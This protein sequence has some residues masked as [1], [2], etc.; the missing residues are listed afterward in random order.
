[1]GST[2]LS[3]L[4]LPYHQM[5]LLDFIKQTAGRK[6]GRRRRRN[7]KVEVKFKKVFSQKDY[8]E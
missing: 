3:C 8:K 7:V 2:G 1:M 5:L 6:A 4:A